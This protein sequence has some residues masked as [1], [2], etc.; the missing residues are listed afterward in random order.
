LRNG[1][2]RFRERYWH[3]P[4]WQG[5]RNQ[6]RILSEVGLAVLLSTAIGVVVG[7]FI[8]VTEASIGAVVVILIVV[9]PF[10]AMLGD[11]AIIFGSKVTTSLHLGQVEAKISMIFDRTMVSHATALLLA[12]ISMCA[13]LGLAG[14][15]VA[16]L[17]GFD[18][19]MSPLAF[20]LLV[21]LA[22]LLV[23][24]PMLWFSILLGYVTFRLGLDPDSFLAPLCS[25][26]SDLL[27]IIGFLASIVLMTTY[28]P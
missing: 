19:P 10:L 24:L 27:G 28:L 11:I 6:Q 4:N 15:L 17:F 18:L 20:F 7:Y 13:C 16:F 2:S 25:V 14:I 1:A 9:P 21:I 3:R 26:V 23:S 12:S 5:L 22:G 8:L